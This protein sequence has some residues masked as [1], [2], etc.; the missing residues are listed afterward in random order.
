MRNHWTARPISWEI[1][2][3]GRGLEG[4]MNAVKGIFVGADGKLRP[5]WRAVLFVVASIVIQ[6]GFLDR[7]FMWIAQWLRIPQTFSPAALSLA[8]FENFLT[9][10]I[11]TAAFALYERRRVDSYRLAINRALSRQTREGAVAGVL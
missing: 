4:R 6:T 11:V 9:A 10:L 8:E 7:S 3:R 5:I 1:M 2:R